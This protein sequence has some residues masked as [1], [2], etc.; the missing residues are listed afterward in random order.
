MGIFDDYFEPQQYESGRGLTGWLEALQQQ[1]AYQPGRFGG[2]PQ[3]GSIVN[4]TMERAPGVQPAP[5]PATPSYPAPF[6][7]GNVPIPTPR[8]VDIPS[9]GIAIGDYLMPQFEAAPVQAQPELGD[10]LSAGF[11]SW[12]Y[13]PV[14]NPF[15]ALANAITGFQ[16]GQ[17]TAAPPLKPPADDATNPVASPA[18]P[19]ANSVTPAQPFARTPTRRRPA[20]WAA[21]ISKNLR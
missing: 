16:T 1:D 19:A 10:R 8:P 2:W 14:G 15:A 4:P 12:A 17:Y 20:R 13:T 6:A 5:V 11:R 9:G 21:S 18:V 3:P 7:V